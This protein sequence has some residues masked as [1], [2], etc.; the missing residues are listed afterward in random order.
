MIKCNPPELPVLSI[1]SKENVGIDVCTII[2]KNLGIKFVMIQLSQKLKL[3]V[4]THEFFYIMFFTYA[5][6]AFFLLE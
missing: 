1:I 5:K 2:S 4:K 3:L 6:A